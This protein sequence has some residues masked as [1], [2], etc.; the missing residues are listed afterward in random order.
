VVQSEPPAE[1]RAA[2]RGLDRRAVA[3][4]AVAR[5]AVDVVA[6]VALPAVD[7]VEWVI[8]EPQPT[9]HNPATINHDPKVT[10]ARGRLMASRRTADQPSVAD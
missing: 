5:R 1:A 9:H 8:E 7:A 2:E 10:A 6:R 4:R 3:R